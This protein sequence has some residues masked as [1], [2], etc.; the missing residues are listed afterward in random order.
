MYEK[1]SYALDR[2]DEKSENHYTPWHFMSTHGS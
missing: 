2:T 1:M